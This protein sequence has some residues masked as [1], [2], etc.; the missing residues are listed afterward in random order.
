MLGWKF[1]GK[2][3]HQTGKEFP[4]VSTVHLRYRVTVWKTLTQFKKLDNITNTGNLHTAE[5]RETLY[6]ECTLDLEFLASFCFLHKKSY[7]V[8]MKK[9]KSLKH[10]RKNNACS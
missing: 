3:K 1:L 9:N 7:L 8:T 6:N 2:L 4:A 10:R 5:T